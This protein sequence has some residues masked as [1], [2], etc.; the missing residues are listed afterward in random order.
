MQ[1]AIA[2][3]ETWVAR[4]PVS[5]QFKFFTGQGVASVTRDTVLVKI[6]TRDGAVGWGQSVPSR[7][8][9]YETLETVRSTIDRYLGPALVGLDPFHEP[10]IKRVFDKTI[11]AGFSTGQPICKAAL[12]LA[13]FDLTGRIL[14]QP[15]A[16]RW[17]RNGREQ[18][19]LSWTVDANSFDDLAASIHE[20][21]DRGYR[22]F[23]VKVGTNAAFDVALC[24]EL[25]RLAPQ[26]FIWADANGGYDAETAMAVAPQLADLG[27]AAFEQPVPANRLGGYARLRRRGALP[28]LMDEGIVSLVDLEEFHALGLLDGVALKI[29]RC[30][31]LSEARRILEFMEQNGLLFFASGLTDPDLS[32]A[33]SLLLFG[34]YGLDRPAALNAP[35]F[36]TGS[37]LKSPIVVEQDR[38]IVPQGV[39]LGVEVDE[40]KLEPH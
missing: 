22:H 2:S 11:A 19:T 6:T 29:S 1:H 20:A 38:A 4:Y 32:L 28:I 23:N 37:F 14:G 13:L 16:Q 36:L 31:G 30:G 15:A 33:A 40:G 25:R 27:L 26:A 21:A 10:G 8:W 17:Q 12:D 24:R 5:G 9:S 39:G 35:Q 18:I 34:A 7:T 3:V